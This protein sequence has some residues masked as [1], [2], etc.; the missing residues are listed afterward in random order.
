MSSSSSLHQ[1]SIYSSNNKKGKLKKGNQGGTVPI[2]SINGLGQ[3]KDNEGLKYKVNRTSKTISSEEKTLLDQEKQ[4]TKSSNVTKSDSKELNLNKD[5]VVKVQIASQE[6]HQL[7]SKNNLF[8]DV[9]SG[10]IY[11]AM[12]QLISKKASEQKGRF[13]KRE[14][15]DHQSVY[16]NSS[17]ELKNKVNSAQQR[18]SNH[19]YSFSHSPLNSN[20]SRPIKS[21]E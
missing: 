15:N 4:K 9:Q 20:N 16:S 8:N 17:N 6:I 14:I 11:K 12:L 2:I 3:W 21:M 13:S 5:Q 10:E 1:Q 19:S 7:L 18:S